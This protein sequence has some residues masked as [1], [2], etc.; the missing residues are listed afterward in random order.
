ML[1]LSLSF[2]LLQS[3]LLLLLLLLL[4]V[5]IVI[6]IVAIIWSEQ[7]SSAWRPTKEYSSRR[8]RQKV[9]DEGKKFFLTGTQ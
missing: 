7:Y 9:S 5:F 2:L 3:L 8:A 6:V 1:S 4:L